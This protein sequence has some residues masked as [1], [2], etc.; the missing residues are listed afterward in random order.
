MGI[1]TIGKIIGFF[2]GFSAAI[3]ILWTSFKY[4]KKVKDTVDIT[5]TI[6]TQFD[7]LLKEFKP[8][9][10]STLKDSITRL[11]NTN[12]RL[13]NATTDIQNKLLNLA[14]EAAY[15]KI[16]NKNIIN[17][18]NNSGYWISNAKGETIEVGIGLCRLLKRNEEELDVIKWM[19]YIHP[20]DRVRVLNEFEHIVQHNGTFNVDYKIALPTTKKE[21]EYIS[22]NAF[23]QPIEINGVM[24]GYY[25]IITQLN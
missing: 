14:K 23:A 21:K 2:L 7:E 24:E 1:E 15:N 11:E 6:K 5:K 10:G 20:D 13:E 17:S 16:A 19:N 4:A 25:G 3:T 8:N 12:V 9:G 18:S 22:V